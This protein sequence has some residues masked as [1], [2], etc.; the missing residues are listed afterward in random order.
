VVVVLGSA[1]PVTD[2]E[3]ASA[4]AAA[5]AQQKRIER[6]VRMVGYVAVCRFVP[7]K[8]PR[9]ESCERTKLGCLIRVDVIAH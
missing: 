8:A 9:S 2:A 7:T 3:K 4:V 6:T 5:A 1:E